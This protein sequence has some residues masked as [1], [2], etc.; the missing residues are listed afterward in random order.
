MSD[1]RFATY[2]E[3]RKPESLHGAAEPKRPTLQQIRNEVSLNL[4]N[5]RTRRDIRGDLPEPWPGTVSAAIDWFLDTICG[6]ETKRERPYLIPTRGNEGQRFEW[7]YQIRV[8]A[9]LSQF[10]ALDQES[11]KRIAKGSAL[12]Y[13]WRGESVAQFEEIA[14]QRAKME[15][16]GRAEFVSTIKKDMGALEKKQKSRHS[17]R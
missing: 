17:E 13:R 11:Q 15:R 5:Y 12:G 3:Q 6:P 10:L 1:D 4:Q 14:R 8:M 2:N 9:T 7:G 16:I